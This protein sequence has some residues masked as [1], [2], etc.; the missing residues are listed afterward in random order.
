MH[1]QPQP[2]LHLTHAFPS[3]TGKPTREHLSRPSPAAFLASPRFPAPGSGRPWAKPQSTQAALQGPHL[4]VLPSPCPKSMH[5]RIPKLIHA[6]VEAIGSLRMNLSSKRGSTL[7]TAAVNLEGLRK[8]VPLKNT[9]AHQPQPPPATRFSSQ[10]ICHTSLP[11]PEPLSEDD[12]S[13]M[14]LQESGC[15]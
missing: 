12:P 15:F 11:V 2:D 7:E 13:L 8:G 14:D 5:G 1:G 9:A 10:C 4:L 3:S 6:E